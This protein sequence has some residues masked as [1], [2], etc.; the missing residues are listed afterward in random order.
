MILITP[1]KIFIED[2][3]LRV[4]LDAQRSLSN[5]LENANSQVWKKNIALPKNIQVL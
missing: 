2:V 5:M 3:P 1:I 4:E